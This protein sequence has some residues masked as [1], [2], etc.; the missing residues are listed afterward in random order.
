MPRFELLIFFFNCL[1]VGI[2]CESLKLIA[3]NLENDWNFGL[4]I[5]IYKSSNIDL[6][7]FLPKLSLLNLFRNILVE[8]HSDCDFELFLWNSIAVY[9]EFF[10][11]E[12]GVIFVIKMLHRIS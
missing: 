10:E 4:K 12:Y 1:F 7:L 11:E 8:K 9:R 6:M 2:F 5:L 3:W